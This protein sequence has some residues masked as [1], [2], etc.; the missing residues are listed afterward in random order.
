MKKRSVG[1]TVFAV[2]FIVGAVLALLSLVTTPKAIEMALTTPGL[3]PET[4][5]QMEATLHLFRS[6][7]GLIAL[8]AIGGLAAGVGLFMLLGWARWL[9]IILAGLSVIQVG[10]SLVTQRGLPTG[11]GA[12]MALAALVFSLAWSGLII[13][14]FLRPSVKAQFVKTT[15]G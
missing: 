11:P 6:R 3:A 7:I 5:T 4:K 14:F 1:V 8:Q 13:W 9:T 12:G 15:T 10:I 2:L